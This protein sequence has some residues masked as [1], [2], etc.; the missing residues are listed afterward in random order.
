MALVCSGR[1]LA[2]NA[3]EAKCHREASDC[4]KACTGDPKEAQRPEHGKR[5]V[6]CVNRCQHQTQECKRACTPSPQK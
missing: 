6:A 1:A 2:Q 4:M 5:L 3:C